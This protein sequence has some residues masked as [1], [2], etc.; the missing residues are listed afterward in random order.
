MTFVPFSRRR[1]RRHVAAAGQ[2]EDPGADGDH[3]ERL[4]EAVDRVLHGVGKLQLAPDGERNPPAGLEDG[5]HQP[6]AVHAQPERAWQ[7]GQSR[8]GRLLQDPR[9][10]ALLVDLAQRELPD[11]L[12]GDVAGGQHAL[13]LE[14]GHGG[15]RLV[16]QPAEGFLGIVVVG[17]EGQEGIAAGERLGGGHGVGRSAG[18]GL[19]GQFDRQPLR[20]GLLLVVAADRFVV[21]SHHQADP[22]IARLRQAGEHVIQEGA[23]DG[24]QRLDARFGGRRLLG[25]QGGRFVR[26]AHPR[27]QAPRENHGLFQHGL[28]HG[29]LAFRIKKNH[30]GHEEYKVGRGA[31]CQP[32][33]LGRLA[34]CPTNPRPVV[35]NLRAFRALCG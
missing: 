25:V 12:G 23:I 33:A 19:D 15:S 29:C 34:I 16:P 27:A 10:P 7:G 22:A 17:V 20:R 32:A 28:D 26:P 2:V 18:L 11:P 35:F 13:Q 8:L 24:D 4:A 9:Q 5:R 31:G 1:D 30:K 3:A 21:R 14:Q 6:P